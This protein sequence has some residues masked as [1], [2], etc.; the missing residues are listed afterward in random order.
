[1]FRHYI[2]VL[3]YYISITCN[4][5][6]F[7]QVVSPTFSEHF[8]G[9]KLTS[10]CLNLVTIHST[11]SSVFRNVFLKLGLPHFCELLQDLFSVLFLWHHL[12]YFLTQLIY[13]F[14]HLYHV[15]DTVQGTKNT[16]R[17]S[18]QLPHDRSLEIS[19]P[20]SLYCRMPHVITVLLF[21]A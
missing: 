4:T 3:N 2:Q 21:P 11:V 20:G 10:T 14:F 12:P 16:T 17:N 13:S 15:S 6:D 5:E 19:V 8:W 18:T 1:M 7:L 9:K